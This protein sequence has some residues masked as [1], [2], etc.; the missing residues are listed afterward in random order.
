MKLLPKNRIFVWLNGKV[1]FFANLLQKI[2]AKTT[3]PAFRLMQIGS[4]FWQSR[5]LYVAT[6]LGLADAIG[7]GQKNTREI[8]S[9]SGLTVSTVNTYLKRIFSK[10]GVHSRVELIARVAGTATIPPRAG[11]E[12]SHADS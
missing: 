9:E 8:A 2:P 11:Y 6:R 10:L 4:L 7:D 5:A 12:A 1:M 3:P